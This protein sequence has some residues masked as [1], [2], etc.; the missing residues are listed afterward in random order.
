MVFVNVFG[1]R[2][3]CLFRLQIKMPPFWWCFYLILKTKLCEFLLLYFMCKCIILKKIINIFMNKN[4]RQKFPNKD[5]YKIL[6]IL[7]EASHKEIKSAYKRLAHE[8]H[9]DKPENQG[10]EE[11]FRDI[12]EAYEILGNPEL[13]LKYDLL[14]QLNSSEAK[15][16]SPKEHRAPRYARPETSRAPQT[17]SSQEKPSANPFS[18]QARQQR[19]EA[20]L[21]AKERREETERRARENRERVEREVRF[22]RE[23]AERDVQERREVAETNAKLRREEDAQ[24]QRRGRS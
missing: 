10:K 7:P 6:N 24:R 20:D 19:E 23:Q 17:Q 12:A 18:H 3:G 8:T 1:E 22:R 21:R 5:L 15:V 16:A 9:P 14:H 11:A 13:R 2:W 4:R